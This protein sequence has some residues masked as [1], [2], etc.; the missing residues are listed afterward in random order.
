MKNR[1]AYLN[2]YLAAKTEGLKKG[3][4]EADGSLDGYLAKQK[5]KL[6]KWKNDFFS[7]GRGAGL[8][9]AGGIAAGLGVALD[10][11][12]RRL[13]DIAR[14]GRLAADIGL[15]VGEF[16]KLSYAARTYGVEADDLSE[17]LKEMNLRLGEAVTDGTGPLNDMFGTLGL[18]VERFSA[19]GPGEAFEGILTALEKLGRKKRAFAADE[20]F[21]GDAN[22]LLPLL[23]AGRDA[24][25]KLADEYERLGLA[26]TAADVAQAKQAKRQRDRNEALAQ[27]SAD[28]AVLTVAP[29][30]G[31][32]WKQTVKRWKHDRKTS[33]GLF[34][35]M[36]V[37]LY[38]ENEHGFGESLQKA[39]YDMAFDIESAELRGRNGLEGFLQKEYEGRPEV[40]RDP[41]VARFSRDYEA[42]AAIDAEAARKQR[43]ADTF[44]RGV[45]LF[46]EVTRQYEKEQRKITERNGEDAGKAAEYFADL[47]SLMADGIA[48]GLEAL[49]LDKLEN[50][51][52]KGLEQAAWWLT[53]DQQLGDDG[54][55]SSGPPTRPPTWRVPSP[56]FPPASPPTGPPSGPRWEKMVNLQEKAQRA[57]GEDRRQ[58]RACRSRDG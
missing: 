15:G 58:G 51:L 46:H 31:W 16:D 28:Q 6:D 47:P 12:D 17:A 24:V 29:A 55:L 48:G 50:R 22:N 19:M 11:V 37:K 27:A 56:R 38:G 53:G 2:I 18:S 44:M 5:R 41:E 1:S 57:A 45:E 32:L 8:A 23:N 35:P 4:K 20:I 10:A 9:I 34:D 39:F 49:E 21:G 33:H 7:S 30:S 25:S 52:P 14:K 36:G 40:E 42:E 54:M 3:L 13:S 43:W 26:L